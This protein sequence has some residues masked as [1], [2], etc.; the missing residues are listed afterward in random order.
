M[1]DWL[2]EGVEI[3]DDVSPATWVVERLRPWGDA[4]VTVGSFMPD[5][6]EAYAR[7]LHP[8]QAGEPFRW[9][10]WAELAGPRGIEITAE[11]RFEE[12]TG[13]GRESGPVGGIDEPYRGSMPGDLVEALVLFLRPWTTTPRTCWFGMWEGNGTWWKGAHSVLTDGEVEAVAEAW[14]IDDERDRVLRA[15]TRFGTPQRQYFL[16]SGPLELANPLTD[17][18]GDSPNLWWPE[19]RAWFVSTEVDGLSSYVGGTVSLIEALLRSETTIE[20]VRASLD[21][22]MDF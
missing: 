13:I 2:P 4:T 19:D 8:A 11:T 18:A 22:R 5:V 15:A 12:A 3:A 17:A 9:A 14:R 10:R 20:A 16:M 1:F 7:I 6:F 21:S